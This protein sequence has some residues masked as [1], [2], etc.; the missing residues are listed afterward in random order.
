MKKKVVVAMSGGVDSS[1]AAALLL[2]QGF[3]VTGITMNLFSL[4]KEYC[5]EENLKS[6]CGRNAVE[7][8]FHV[9]L[10][11]GIPHYTADMRGIFEKKVISDFC[12]EYSL[13]RTPNPCIRCNQYIKFDLLLEKS[14]KLNADFLATGHYARILK[15][16]NTGRYLL[17]KGKDEKK[18]QSYFLYTL[19]QNQMARIL[20]PV[21]ESTKEEI[22]KKAEEF[23]LPVAKRPESQEICF[24]PDNNYAGFLKDKIPEAFKPG[25]IVDIDGN[26]LGKHSGIIHYTIGQ[27]R[28][29]GI[30][31]PDPLYVLAIGK[32]KNEIVAG[33]DD[34]LYKKSLSA[35]GIN[36]IARENLSGEIHAKARIRYKHKEAD[37]V[38]KIN[39]HGLVEVTFKKPQRAI[40]PG[41]A[42]V[43]YEG[44]VVIGGGTII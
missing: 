36:L 18:D 29:M 12:K 24:I 33:T 19:T 4:P 28:G 17:K 23:S 41:Q 21:G 15:D 6:C 32:D 30:A 31:A 43:F 10:V 14:K 38:I 34:Q 7:D 16:P 1:V 25:N 35:S 2:D 37:A 27:R 26:V 40:T 39:G 22:R 5:S 3:D 8:A 13:G 9:A 20:M 44:D 42:V 11:L